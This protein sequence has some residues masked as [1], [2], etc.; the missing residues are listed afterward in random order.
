M[1]VPLDFSEP[2]RRAIEH[3]LP[4]VEWFGSQLH[5]MHVVE[6]DYAFNGI[7]GLPLILPEAETGQRVRHHLRDWAKSYDVVLDRDQ[8]HVTKG[9]PFEEICNVARKMDIDLIMMSTHGRTGLKR[10]ALGSTA[11]RVVR[12][13]PCPVLVVPGVASGKSFGN[14]KSATAIRRIV[15]PVDFSECSMKGLAY[16]KA[17]ARRFDATLILLH[18]IA[19]QHYINSDEYAR[20]DYPMVMKQ[21]EQGA[22]DHMA[23]LVQTLRSEGIKVE[24]SLQIGHAGEQVCA[25]AE[26]HEADLVVTSTHG[27]TGLG[28][29][30][31]G[32]T[33]EFVVR[34]SQTPVL[35]V[36]SHERP[37]LGPMREK[38]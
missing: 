18:S 1:L 2:S 8:I 16:A 12:F 29:L 30:L 10:L 28:H 7:M 37:V 6:P 35:V 3:A 5:F 21:A 17:L 24:S 22:R 4:L 19:L 20:Y 23:E 15:V 32:S 27:R 25:G 9:Q 38:Q 31:I 36:P 26:K 13:S 11:E 14:G 34:H 33:A